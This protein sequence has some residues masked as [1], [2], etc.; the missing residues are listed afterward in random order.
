MIS[1]VRVLHLLPLEQLLQLLAIE[2]LAIEIVQDVVAQ[3]M[4]VHVLK[5]R[6]LDLLQILDLFVAL[7]KLKGFEG[8]IG[9]DVVAS[10]GV[11][12]CSSS[13]SLKNRF[14]ALVGLKTCDR[15]VLSDLG[16]LDLA[17]ERVPVPSMGIESRDSPIV[18]VLDE[19]H[20]HLQLIL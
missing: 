12:P 16:L 1:L 5:P 9:S 3:L 10:S 15:A 11:I 4:E 6:R 19:P 20:L 2:L 8:I 18:E 17:F 14:L 13:G 7:A